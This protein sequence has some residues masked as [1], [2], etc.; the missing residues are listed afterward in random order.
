MPWRRSRV[1]QDVVGLELHAEV[2]TGPAPPARRSRTAGRPACPS[3]RARRRRRC[4]L[5][6][7]RSSIGSCVGH[8]RFVLGSLRAR[9]SAA[10]A[11]AARRPSGRPAPG[12][13]SDA[14]AAA[15]CRG[16]RSE[17]TWAR[18]VVAVAAQI[19]DRHLRVGQASW[20]S[21]SISP[22]LIGI[23]VELPSGLDVA[24]HVG[25]QP[26]LVRALAARASDMGAVAAECQRVAAGRPTA[27]A[28]TPRRAAA[29]SSDAPRRSRGR[30]QV[31]ALVLA[32]QPAASRCA[33]SR[34]QR[35]ARR[36]MPPARHISASGHGEAA[37]GRGR[38][39]R[40]TR[41]AAIWPRTKSPCAARRRDRPAAARPSSRPTSSRR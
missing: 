19:L 17:T 28:S 36:P 6:R 8:P 37:V 9:W 41:P 4:D 29:A 16:T 20:I 34:G 40:A 11:R 26:A 14:A 33:A 12:R 27:R 31:A 24:G 25:R 7:M 3:C 10:P 35:R 2:A 23:A 39:R 21:R 18:V 30:E 15:T 32:E 38:G 13:P 5:L 22:A 1:V